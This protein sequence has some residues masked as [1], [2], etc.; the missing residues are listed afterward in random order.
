ML[1]QNKK[2]FLIG[3]KSFIQTNLYNHLKK[4]FIVNK[5]KFQDIYKK[6]ITNCDVIINFSNSKKFYEKEYNKIYDRNLKIANIIKKNNVK[7]FLLSTRQVY[8]QKLYL[9]E[10]SK[11]KPLNLYAKNCLYSEKNCRKILK[12]NLV[13]LRL[14]NINGYELATNLK[15]NTPLK[16][17]TLSKVTLVRKGQVVDVFA[18]GNGI[19]VTMKGMAL[20]DG[21]EGGVVTVRN[22][23][24]DKKFQAKVLNENSVKVHL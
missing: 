5:I 24:S 8:A 9:T 20:D 21:V 7:F 4:N 12:K 14:S 17:N 11:L 23:S 16:W 3:Y 1:K 6:K 13:I 2:I 10:K 15:P 19:Y 18:S 22:L